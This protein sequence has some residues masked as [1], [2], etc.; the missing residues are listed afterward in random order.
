[1]EQMNENQVD[2]LSA[3]SPPTMMAAVLTRAISE[4]DAVKVTEAQHVAMK[5]ELR[6]VMKAMRE[7]VRLFV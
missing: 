4:L 5:E 7:D 1:M 2:E 6:E 3:A